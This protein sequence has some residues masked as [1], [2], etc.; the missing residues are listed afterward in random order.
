MKLVRFETP[1]D[2]YEHAAGRVIRIGSE[3]VAARDRFLVALSG[4]ET[5]RLLY[6]RLATRAH[7]LDWSSVH[8]FWSD[9]RCVPP[10][11]A[12]S[13]YAMARTTL[14]DHVPIPADRIHRIEGEKPPRDAADAYEAELRRILAEDGRFDLV[15]L[16]IGS[17]G[18]TASLFP[19]H[20]SLAEQNRWAV[21][22]H[23]P[24]DPAWRVTLT[25][26]PI[27]AARHVLFLVTGAEKAEAVRQL[28]ADK[29]IPAALVRPANGTLTVLLDRAAASALPE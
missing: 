5:P 12:R 20:Q 1:D 6:E 4:G 16:G 2:L 22:A 24:V 19:G 7:E 23:A 25:L 18:H 15:I 9:E 8:V 14:L 13:N 27:N 26:L 29:S 28:D 17:D 3:A 11:D 21:P 10:T